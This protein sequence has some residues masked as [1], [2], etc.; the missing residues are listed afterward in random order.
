MISI[1]GIRIP[2]NQV[3]VQIDADYDTFQ[4]G[5]KETNLIS[6]NYAYQNGNRISTPSKNFSVK[7]KVYGVPEKIQ[8]NREE[9]KAINNNHTLVKKVGDKHQVANGELLRKINDLKKESCRFE[10]DNELEVGDTVKFSYFVHIT[11][12]ENN[13][14]FDTAE[15]KMYF[16]KYDDIFMT[17]NDDGSPKKM[18][19]GYILVD[20]DVREIKK[21][22]GM[23]YEETGSGLIIPKINQ[24]SKQ[25][26]GMKCMEGKVLLSAQP[27]TKEGKAG[28]YFDI[29]DYREIPIEVNEGDRILFDPRPS[30]QLEHENHQAMADHK[31]YLIQRKDILFMEKDN[32]GIFGEIGMDKVNYERI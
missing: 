28:G 18:I 30:Q 11:A 20:P 9:I 31:I 23:E 6:P 15:G 10:T 5:G 25:K 12:K 24:D 8:F 3:L 32:I 26:R 1:Q 7:G 21:E 4:L 17:V 16:I 2:L 27:L 19:N 29:E 13:A 14:I 22:G